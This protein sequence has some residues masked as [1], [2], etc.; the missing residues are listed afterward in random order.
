MDNQKDVVCCVEGCQ[1]TVSD[2]LV[3]RGIY[4]CLDH[5]EEEGEC[6]QA[7]VSS[8]HDIQINALGSIA[9]EDSYKPQS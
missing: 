7:D 2:L 4:K 8:W 6:Y 5:R 1:G 3:D 9:F